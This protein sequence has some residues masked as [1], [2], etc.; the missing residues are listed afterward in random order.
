M[1]SMGDDI[2]QHGS[3]L[4]QAMCDRSRTYDNIAHLYIES[5][6][7]NPLIKTLS[8]KNDAY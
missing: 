5:D 2:F 3:N 1:A 8:K 6:K 7:S 4:P